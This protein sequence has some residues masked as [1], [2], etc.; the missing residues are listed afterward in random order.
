M[1]NQPKWKDL[2]TGQHI[3]VDYKDDQVGYFVPLL[4]AAGF[5]T[6]VC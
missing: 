3:F 1:A 6:D 5:K 4:K 2:I